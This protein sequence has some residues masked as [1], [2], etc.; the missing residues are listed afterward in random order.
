MIIKRQTNWINHPKKTFTLKTMHFETVNFN[1]IQILHYFGPFHCL[2]N[3]DATDRM[4]RG[5]TLKGVFQCVSLYGVIIFPTGRLG[6]SRYIA[7]SVFDL[8]KPSCRGDGSSGKVS[9]STSDNIHQSTFHYPIINDYDD[10]SFYIIVTT[11]FTPHA[12][13]W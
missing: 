13:P 9:I 1:F 5:D 4:Q 10:K 8:E 7:D 3:C 6:F 11:N 12:S 2:K